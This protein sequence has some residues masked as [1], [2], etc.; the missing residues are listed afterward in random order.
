MN[1]SA[2]DRAGNDRGMSLMSRLLSE[3][4]ESR[5][6]ANGPRVDEAVENYRSLGFEVKTVPFNDLKGD[7]CTICF[8]DENDAT[9]MIFTRKSKQQ[10][11]RHKQDAGEE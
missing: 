7:G 10:A 11:A 9:V 8:E 4:W 1:P 6:T 3:G 2:D 5:F